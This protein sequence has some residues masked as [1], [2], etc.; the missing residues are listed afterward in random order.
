MHGLCNVVTY[1]HVII[2]FISN[3]CW[4]GAHVLRVITGKGNGVNVG[5]Q[6]SRKH[7]LICVDDPSDSET[8]KNIEMYLHILSGKLHENRV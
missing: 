5:L 1:N 7:T 8:K 3:F 2:L 6:N 4:K